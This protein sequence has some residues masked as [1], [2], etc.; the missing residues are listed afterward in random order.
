MTW[1]APLLAVFLWLGLRRPRPGKGARVGIVLAS[2][3]ALAYAYLGL[4]S[5]G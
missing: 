2:C 3:A 5:A 4:S 1:I